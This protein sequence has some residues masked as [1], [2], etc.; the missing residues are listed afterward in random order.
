MRQAS[1][2]TWW[3]QRF[4]AALSGFTDSGRLQR[5]RAYS[6][7]KR[8]LEFQVSDG[9]V[10]ATVRGNINPYFDVYEEPRYEISIQLVPFGAK[11][12]AGAT[13]KIGTNAGLVARL[14]MGELPDEIDAAFAGAKRQLLPVTS[15]DFKI[16]ECSCP[17]FANPCKHIAGVYYRLAREMD[18][19]PF[20][21]FELRGMQ[22]A[23]LRAELAGT[24]LGLALASLVDEEPVSTGDATSLVARP[25][26]TSESPDYR[27][28]WLGARPLPGES[29]PM[30]HAAVPAILVKKGGDYPAFWNNDASFIETME[31]LYLQ[32]RTKNKKQL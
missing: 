24:P 19:D 2:R 22:R 28:F 30:Q 26:P 32:V 7:D 1:V 25:E 17:D 10:R 20:L 18:A 9:L 5:G 27:A 21:L 6:S 4:M 14:L 13:K 16:T 23:S 15:K 11:A 31:A 29:P 3:G 8:I 12:W